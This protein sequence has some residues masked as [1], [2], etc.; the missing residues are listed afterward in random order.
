[1]FYDVFTYGSDF[2]KEQHNYL[3]GRLIFQVY[4]TCALP[5]Q[6][7][8]D[9]IVFWFQNEHFPQPARKA[10]YRDLKTSWHLNYCL[11]G[12]QG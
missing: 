10:T 8:S 2:R 12:F 3:V 4:R 6:F 9:L 7:L 11:P 5:N 1:M